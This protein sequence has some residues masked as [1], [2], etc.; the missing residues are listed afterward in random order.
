MRERERDLFAALA[1]TNMPADS[2]KPR[3]K[4]WCRKTFS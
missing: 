2:Q 4:D 1:L 3:D